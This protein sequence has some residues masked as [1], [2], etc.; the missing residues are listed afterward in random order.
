VEIPKGK[1]PLES[2]RCRWEDNIKMDPREAGCGMNWIHLARQGPAE[3]SYEQGNEP[4]GSIKCSE[5][6]EWLSN[7]WLLRNDSATLSLAS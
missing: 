1:T 6:L 7:W 2:P 4:S 3:G 5:I